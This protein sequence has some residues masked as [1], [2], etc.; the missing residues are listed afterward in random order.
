MRWRDRL[1]EV[2][3]LRNAGRAWSVLSVILAPLGW[4]YGL[5]MR[6]RAWGYRRGWLCSEAAPCPVVSVG[7]ITAGG[8]GKTPLTIYLAA[9]LQ[10]RGHRVVVVSRGYRGSLE[11]QTAVV[12]DGKQVL[13]DA[14]TAGDEPVLMARNLPGVPVII[15][16]R[17][18]MAARLAGQRFA[19]DVIVCDDAFSHLAL[20]RVCDIVVT[21]GRDGLG[22][23]RCL[24]AGPLREPASALRRAQ[25]AVLNVTAGFDPRTEREMCAAGFQGPIHHLTYGIPRWRRHDDAAPVDPLT[26]SDRRVL[27]FAATARPKD[28][29]VSF[30]RAGW[31]LVHCETFPDHHAYTAEDLQHL[32]QLAAAQGICYLA[33]TEKDAVK[34][35]VS[36]PQ[37]LPLLVAGIT[38]EGVGESLERLVDHVEEICWPGRPSF[39]T[40]TER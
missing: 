27:A 14:S 23:G 34:L 4:F 6:L 25:V 8:T 3:Y 21:H 19:A 35:P 12:S 5:L 31:N 7:N 22:N 30:T 24:P 37:N 18:P 29:F 15:G 1:A 17:R 20:Q 11:G 39:S 38:P 32:A 13:L 10:R 33:T 16:A 28:V 26:C 36:L 40:A 2:L 9:A